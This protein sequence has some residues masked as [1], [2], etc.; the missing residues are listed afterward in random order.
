MRR[1]IMV[2]VWV[3]V[4]CGCA[5]SGQT[6]RFND[7]PLSLKTA[8]VV[9]VA[10]STLDNRAYVRSGE[11]TSRYIGK[12]R[13]TLGKAWDVTTDSG[14][15]LADDFTESVSASLRKG[16][17]PVSPV[18]SEPGD[19]QDSLLKRMGATGADRLVLMTIEEWHSDTYVATGLY[20]NL[21]LLITDGNGLELGKSTVSGQEDLGGSTVN[22]PHYAKE[23]IPK[24]YK[25]EIEKLFRY[26]SIMKALARS[27]PDL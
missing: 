3:S 25:E 14:K 22:P 21:V 24:A 9:K 8:D 15:P 6:V 19:T 10:V 11:K 1:L 13:S 23:A 17:L 26:P 4:L 12:F 27:R 20:Y 5:A 7:V 18:W 2:L 16:G